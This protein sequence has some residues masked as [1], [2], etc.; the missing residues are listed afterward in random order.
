MY[1]M[2]HEVCNLT[3]ENAHLEAFIKPNSFK[4]LTEG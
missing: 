3:S 2:L 4:Y 1:Y